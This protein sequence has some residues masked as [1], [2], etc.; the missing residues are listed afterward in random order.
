MGAIAVDAW[1]SARGVFPPVGKPWSVS[2]ALDTKDRAVY[3]ATLDTRFH[4]S[5]HPDGWGYAFTHNGRHS[6]ITIANTPSVSG[7]DDHGL[8]ASTPSLANVGALVRELERRYAVH[9][10]RHAATVSTDLLGAEPVVRAWL[11]SI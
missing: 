1:L 10:P 8:L 4:L 2:V 3:I 11:T 7:R 6:E 5:I 9:F